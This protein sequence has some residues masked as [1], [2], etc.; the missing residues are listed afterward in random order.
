MSSGRIA[1]R[2]A[3]FSRSSIAATTE[4]VRG[5]EADTGPTRP[6]A[7]ELNAESC[8]VL[9]TVNMVGRRARTIVSVSDETMRHN[10]GGAVLSLV[11]IVVAAWLFGSGL[12]RFA[13]IL[14]VLIGL[15]RITSDHA[16][17]RMWAFVGIGVV[18][19]LF[20]HW[21]WAFKH[22][23][24][25][26]RLAL[27]VFSGPGSR[28]LAPIPTNH[29]PRDRAERPAA[30][31]RRPRLVGRGRHASVRRKQRIAAVVTRLFGDQILAAHRERV[32]PRCLTDQ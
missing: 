17:P 16:S 11:V 31:S 8:R 2:S 12:A 14:L 30:G 5:M 29:I 18:L 23:L 1:K 3:L 25:R 28:L 20:G 32:R 24:W 13:G 7:T 21:L 15:V 22:K 19:W 9:T 6:P 10:E 27:A 26:S 4:P